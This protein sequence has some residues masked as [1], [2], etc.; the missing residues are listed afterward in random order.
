MF[1]NKFLDYISIIVCMQAAIL[2]SSSID[3]R[4]ACVNLWLEHSHISSEHLPVL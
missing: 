4:K 2:M 3:I 1:M